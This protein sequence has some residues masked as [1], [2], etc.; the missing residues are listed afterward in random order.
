M[1][2]NRSFHY[3]RKYLFD[4]SND[5]GK[6]VKYTGIG[7]ACASALPA[8]VSNCD[9]ESIANVNGGIRFLR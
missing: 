9:S 2:R 8:V 5:V 4:R 6:L 3:L 1:S 7:V